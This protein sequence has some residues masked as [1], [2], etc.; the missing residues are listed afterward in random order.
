MT[1]LKFRWPVQWMAVIA[2]GVIGVVSDARAAVRR[3]T[4]G[5]HL[6][7]VDR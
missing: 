7:A 4:P 1:K 5:C 3:G 6:T 2:L